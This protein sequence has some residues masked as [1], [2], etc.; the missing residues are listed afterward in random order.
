M[1]LQGAQGVHRVLRRGIATL[2]RRDRTRSTQ[3]RFRDFPDWNRNQLGIR[4][5]RKTCTARNGKTSRRAGESRCCAEAPGAVVGVRAAGPRRGYVTRARSGS[6]A[7]FTPWLARPKFS[8]SRPA[9]V[10]LLPRFRRAFSRLFRRTGA[11]RI[12]AR[13]PF[14]TWGGRNGVP[15]PRMQDTE[16]PQ[17]PWAALE[18][19][20]V[21]LRME[22][23]DRSR[24][25][26]TRN[27]RVPTR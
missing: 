21:F 2:K 1:P 11:V 19:G 22:E 26:Q 17:L 14:A 4:D 15:R 5:H 23:R 7:V 20:G 8:G 25:A 13:D 6:G 27:A 24:R 16:R 3:G 18:R 12:R 10:P 9:F